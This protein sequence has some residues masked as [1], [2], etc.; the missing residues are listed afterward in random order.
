MTSLQRRVHVTSEI[1]ALVLA[2][3]LLFYASR[4]LPNPN[5]RTLALGLAIGTVVVDGWLLWKFS[6][7]TARD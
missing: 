3:P 2:A 6:Q 7:A 1:A 4:T 5:A